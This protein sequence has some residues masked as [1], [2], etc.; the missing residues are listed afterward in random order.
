MLRN[1]AVLAIAGALPGA[2][3]NASAQTVITTDTPIVKKKVA[4]HQTPSGQTVV[5]KKVVVKK[6]LPKKVTVVRGVGHPHNVVVARQA[7]QKKKTVKKVYHPDGTQTTV[8][9]RTS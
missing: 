7:V 5:K 2:W 4:V 3:A 1:L 8:I 9:K 6:A